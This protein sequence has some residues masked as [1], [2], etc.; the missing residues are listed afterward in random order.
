MQPGSPLVQDAIDMYNQLF[1]KYSLGWKEPS[2]FGATLA[3][4]QWQ[5]DAGRQRERADHAE[6]VAERSASKAEPESLRQSLRAAKTEDAALLKAQ[7]QAP[8]FEA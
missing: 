7:A 2:T 8:L 5:I 1:Q 4:M 6:L 3:K